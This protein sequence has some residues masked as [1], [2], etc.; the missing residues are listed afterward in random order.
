M[1]P[2]EHDLL[3]LPERDQSF[4]DDRCFL[5]G[6]DLNHVQRTDEHVFPRW[7]L[8][9]YGL[10]NERLGL[11][12]RTT[13]RYRQLTIPC[14][15]DCNTMHLSQI[16]RSVQEAWDEGPDAVRGLDCNLLFLWMGKIYYGIL[17]RELLL[18]LDRRRE[19]T[20]PIVPADALAAFQTHHTLLQRARGVV[21]WGEDCPAS[22]FVFECQ[23]S[24]ENLRLNFDY[25]DH[26]VRPFF[27]IR[28]GAIGLIATLQ[29]WGALKTVGLEMFQTARV[30]TLHPVQFRGLIAAGQCANGL[31]NRTPLHLL[32]TERDR[33]HIHT[34]PPTG[35][36]EGPWFDDWDVEIYANLLA[37]ALGQPLESVWDGS[38][39]T[40]LIGTPDN[41]HVIAWDGGPWPMVTHRTE[42]E[43]A[44]AGIE[45]DQSS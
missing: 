8:R 35:S 6:D 18:P 23:E 25:G 19:T 24:D 33:V 17:F 42:E 2:T 21:T 22:V 34:A 5:C 20:G 12:N 32:A 11:L 40:N 27:A 7:L 38:R 41:P 26:F 1:S 39:A 16:E 4:T 36:R 14:C 3:Y 31:F 15:H 28:G 29:D 44:Q 10:W 30:L 13:V 37:T 9:R 45:T 43:L